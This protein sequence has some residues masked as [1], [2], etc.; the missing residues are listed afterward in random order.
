MLRAPAPHLDY[1]QNDT[2]REIFYDSYDL[3]V[4]FGDNKNEPNVLMGVFDNEDEKLGVML[5]VWKPI[6]PDQVYRLEYYYEVSYI[7]IL[8]RFVIYHWQLWM[9]E[10]L[11]LKI[12]FFIIF[13]SISY[14]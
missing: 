1:H 7:L 8:Y 5:G 12:K 13:I 6:Q 3:P 9:Q 14:S 10:H 4:P 11:N 2:E